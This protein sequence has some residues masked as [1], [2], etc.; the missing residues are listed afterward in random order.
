VDEHPWSLQ[1]WATTN[2]FRCSRFPCPDLSGLAP[3]TGLSLQTTKRKIGV[4]KHWPR[5]RRRVP[6][7]ECSSDVH[8]RQ[9]PDDVRGK[10]PSLWIK[11]A[12]R[13]NVRVENCTIVS[14]WEL[15]SIVLCGSE[16]GLYRGGHAVD[17]TED[18]VLNRRIENGLRFHRCGD[19]AEGSLV[20]S[21]YTSIPGEYRDWK[22]TTLNLTFTDQ[23]GHD[24]S[25]RADAALQKSAS[26][27][28]SLRL[29]N[30]DVARVV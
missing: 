27:K 25:A 12:L 5:D 9:I 16:R 8:S 15:E 10:H 21:G 1:L 24:H 7:I 4:R 28:N 30:T 17:F 6:G 3:E 13:S 22:I 29:P 23:F 26:G 19:V 18:E 20:A 14:V 2:R 11:T